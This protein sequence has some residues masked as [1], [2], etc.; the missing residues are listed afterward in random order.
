VRGTQLILNK[1][2]VAMPFDYAN[3]NPNLKALK[4]ILFA[5]IAAAALCFAVTLTLI[6]RA[7][8]HGQSVHQTLPAAHAAAVYANRKEAGTMTNDFDFL[9][10]AE[11]AR[12]LHCSK[13]HVCNAVAG[14]LTGCAPI[15]SSRSA[16]ES[17]CAAIALRVD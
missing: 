2:Q 7:K 12:V 3:A 10:L 11:V 15:P 6:A 1:T 14:R 17:S 5:L 13:A 4:R 16:A 8:P 9:T